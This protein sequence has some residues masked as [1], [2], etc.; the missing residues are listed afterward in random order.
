VYIG[1]RPEDQGRGRGRIPVIYVTWDYAKKY[2]RWLSRKTGQEYRQLSEAEWEYMA[3][4]GST[5]KYP[6]G[7]AISA[8]RAK[9][10]SRD[11]TVPVGSYAANAFG[12]YDT[13]GN[14]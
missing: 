2:V 14:V 12:I 10:S 7:N 5:T 13:L 4:A 8:S 1:Y 11:G 6:W 3:R 9:Y